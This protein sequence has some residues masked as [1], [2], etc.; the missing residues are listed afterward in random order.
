[1]SA[2]IIFPISYHSPIP[3]SDFIQIIIRRNMHDMQINFLNFSLVQIIKERITLI[4]NKTS[5]F[6]K[7]NAK[8][9]SNAQ[10]GSKKIVCRIVCN[11]VEVIFYQNYTENTIK[12]DRFVSFDGGLNEQLLVV[13]MTPCELNFLVVYFNYKFSS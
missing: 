6:T 2:D 3:F 8:I 4:V 7:S 9:T 1:M 5:Y 10:Y 12:L 13:N 11:D